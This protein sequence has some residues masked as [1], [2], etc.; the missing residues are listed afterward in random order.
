MTLHSVW[1]QSP[2]FWDEEAPV[3]RNHFLL[4]A[5]IFF[6]LSPT[7]HAQTH[8]T[9]VGTINLLHAA[10]DSNEGKK[11]LPAIGTKVS[12]ERQQRITPTVQAI[13][14]KMAPVDAKFAEDNGL[15]VVTDTSKQLPEP[16]IWSKEPGGNILRK[17]VDIAKLIIDDYGGSSVHLPPVTGD[18]SVELI[19]LGRATFNTDEGNR[20]LAA[21]G[22][23]ATPEQK[24][25]ISQ[26]IL[27]KMTPLIAKFAGDS[28]ADI[29]IDI[30]QQWPMCSVVWFDNRLDITQRVVSAY[31]ER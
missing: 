13:L 30:S 24:Q 3:L 6:P 4:A 22:Y 21:I 1:G 28:G 19:N 8:N 7:S 20:E 23:K 17:Q 12:Q 10:F 18:Q 31:N 2:A 26:R 5:T 15:G 16:V 11:E 14:V 9:V 25:E 29:V 27:V